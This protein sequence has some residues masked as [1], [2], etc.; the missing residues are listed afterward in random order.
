MAAKPVIM[1]IC[2]AQDNDTRPAGFGGMQQLDEVQILSENDR[3]MV[4][5][6]SKDFV[7][8]GSPGT[9]S[10]P[11]L[12]LPAEPPQARQSFRAK[13]QVRHQL[14]TGTALRSF[15]SQSRSLASRAAYSRQASISAASRQGQA[16]RMRARECPAANWRNTLATVTRIPRIQGRPPFGVD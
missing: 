11:M 7:I 2:D 1:F 9:Q 8:F 13:V 12:N 15:G 5:G 4:S 10:L 3:L 14:H 6:P 16:L